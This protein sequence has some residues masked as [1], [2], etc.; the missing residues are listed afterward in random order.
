MPIRD[1]RLADEVEDDGEIIP[2]FFVVR[3]GWNDD[4][5]E[6]EGIASWSEIHN[7]TLACGLQLESDEEAV[8]KYGRTL[9]DG[10]IE[11]A[12]RVTATVMQRERSGRVGL[13]DLLTPLLPLPK[14]EGFAWFL[15]QI[16]GLKEQLA[17]RLNA[18]VP[19][20]WP[21][22]GLNTGPNAP[23]RSYG[24]VTYRSGA[25]FSARSAATLR[26]QNVMNTSEVAKKEDPLQKEYIRDMAMAVNEKEEELYW[27]E[28]PT[29]SSSALASASAAAPA[30]AIH[31]ESTNPIVLTENYESAMVTAHVGKEDVQATRTTLED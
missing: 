13:E 9:G 11:R 3:L 21:D 29:S 30:V 10:V 8:R 26:A 22:K 17:A 16:Q 2:Y 31:T 6:I 15:E 18:A 12:D 28:Y 14:S 25:S 19:N 27:V 20:R 7:W 23:T 5:N 1:P 4:T 24:G